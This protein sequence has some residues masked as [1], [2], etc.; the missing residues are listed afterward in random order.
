MINNV[1]FPFIRD[2]DRRDK[3]KVFQIIIIGVKFIG[4]QNFHHM[5]YFSVC[6]NFLTLIDK[7][8]FLGKNKN[9]SKG[10]L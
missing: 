3:F 8:D 5:A 7:A 6:D 2:R 10:K 1:I 9:K 4:N